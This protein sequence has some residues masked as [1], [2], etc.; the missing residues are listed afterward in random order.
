M[1]TFKTHKALIE[2]PS[3]WRVVLESF[4]KAT[5]WY[6][7]QIS[8]QAT[9]LERHSSF[10]GVYQ[11]EL[12][13][14]GT[15][16]AQPIFVIRHEK[17]GG[18]FV[19]SIHAC[20]LQEDGVK[21]DVVRLRV[22][23]PRHD[24]FEKGAVSNNMLYLTAF[25]APISG[26]LWGIDLSKPDAE[27]EWIMTRPAPAALKQVDR[28]V[29]LGGD[30]YVYG[31]TQTT[32]LAPVPDRED[33][34]RSDIL[35]ARAQDGIVNQPWKRLAV[36]ASDN[37]PP[38]RI[39][40][41]F[42]GHQSPEGQLS[43]YLFGGMD[44]TA[45]NMSSMSEPMKDLWKLDVTTREWSEPEQHGTRPCT[46]MVTHGA[47]ISP[48]G[49]KAMVAGGITAFGS[50]HFSIQ[51]SA[52]EC[53]VPLPDLFELDLNTTCWVQI[54]PKGRKW[55]SAFTACGGGY[56][57]SNHICLLGLTHFKQLRPDLPH[58]P[59]K[60]W[61]TALNIR[62]QRGKDSVSNI[63]ACDRHGFERDRVLES[64]AR[65][66]VEHR[67]RSEQIQDPYL[68]K[69][70]QMDARHHAFTMMTQHLSSV[71]IYAYTPQH[72][73]INEMPKQFGSMLKG[74]HDII[75]DIQDSL[76]FPFAEPWSHP[77][78]CPFNVGPHW[79]GGYNEVSS[80]VKLTEPPS[81]EQQYSGA[82]WF[83]T[84]H[85]AIRSFPSSKAALEYYKLVFPH[86]LAED[87]SGGWAQVEFLEDWTPP[88]IG[89]LSVALYAPKSGN[90]AE[91]AHYPVYVTAVSGSIAKFNVAILCGARHEMAGQTYQC[92]CCGKA[93]NSKSD[94]SKEKPKVCECQM[95]R[96]C[97]RNCQS[98]H[99]AVHKPICKAAR[100]PGGITQEQALAF[101]LS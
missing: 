66:K 87:Q 34:V 100:Q 90:S 47:F 33:M 72:K 86:C 22:F 81:K 83:D 16:N 30:L 91:Q 56:L 51:I 14:C 18:Q 43:L 19:Y 60:D 10:Q 62:F 23:A 82:P 6:P 101:M 36:K 67:S 55:T 12:L 65:N 11:S 4:P 80:G 42:F 97:C 25:S 73:D 8:S 88:E 3:A 93:W 58:L 84:L 40:A 79:L 74:K 89:E 28:M 76:S 1:N 61:E 21:M 98:S 99:W 94:S 77:D 85:H 27:P 63:L 48:D 70:L 20:R 68:R 2:T 50:E 57:T 26:A 13:N 29:A 92:A 17:I 71:A 37:L 59:V 7:A 64:I 96:Y 54:V 75:T 45:I 31:G 35:V 49:Q 9:Q 41:C 39:G 38:K 69:L 78:L 5:C 32:A 46:R 52:T 24:N 44:V 15:Y 53:S 95:A